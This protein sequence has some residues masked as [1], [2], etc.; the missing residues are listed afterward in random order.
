MKIK[1]V[2]FR[3]RYSFDSLLKGFLDNQYSSESG[4]G[5]ILTKADNRVIKG[6][7]VVKSLRKENVQDPFGDSFEREF[8]V[9]ETVEFEVLSARPNALK[10]KNPP[11]KLK[12]FLQDFLDICGFRS[13]VS[14]I[15]V[16]CLSLVSFFE[17]RGLK[18]QV[19]QMDLE[20]IPISERT[21]AVLTLKGVGDVRSSFGE[22]FPGRAV[23][24]KKLSM[25]IDKD[26]EKCSFLVAST[27]L[28]VLAP[29]R[30]FPVSFVDELLYDFLLPKFEE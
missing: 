13:S 16:D 21:T 25:T 18:C 4:R 26:G 20:S 22:V 24:A 29:H 14:E 1:W 30:S 23:K 19:T 17:S 9:F 28:T 2:A 8:T 10:L 7:H 3:T 27:G 11:R 6:T 12:I 15:N 5:F